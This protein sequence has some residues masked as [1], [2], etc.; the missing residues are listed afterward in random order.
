MVGLANQTGLA[1]ARVLYLSFKRISITWNSVWANF[2]YYPVTEPLIN[3]I[4][5]IV[6]GNSKYI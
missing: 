2:A 5:R 6:V 3:S 1:L 4:E